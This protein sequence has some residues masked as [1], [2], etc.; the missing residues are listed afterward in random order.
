MGRNV[1]EVT[2]ELKE[3]SKFSGVHY[4]VFYFTSKFTLILLL[5]IILDYTVHLVRIGPFATGSVPLAKDDEKRIV[6]TYDANDGD[7]VMSIREG[8]DDG[9]W[10][11]DHA[12]MQWKP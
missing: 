7:K 9:E 11:S 8:V 6:F 12:N 2:K 4:S 5:S 3:Q 1:Q 10:L